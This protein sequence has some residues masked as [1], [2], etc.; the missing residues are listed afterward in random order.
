MKRNLLISFFCLLCR[1]R[2]FFQDKFGPGHIVSDTIAAGNYLRREM[3]SYTETE[4][5][6]A[7]P[8]VTL[9]IT[10]S[11]VKKFLNKNYNL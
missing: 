11:S 7:E 9:R 1:T 2:T 8:T 4:G 3:A 6:I 5:E 10:V